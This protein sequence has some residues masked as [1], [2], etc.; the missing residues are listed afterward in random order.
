MRSTLVTSVASIQQEENTVKQQ[1]HWYLELGLIYVCLVDTAKPN[2]T[3]PNPT[4]TN[5]NQHT[6]THTIKRAGVKL[7]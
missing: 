7:L 2:P 4:Q 5:Q 6:Y 3:Q 1:Y